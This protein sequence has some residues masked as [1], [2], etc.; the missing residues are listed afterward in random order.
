MLDRLAGDVSFDKMCASDCR[1]CD[2]VGLKICSEKNR[3]Q[4][5]S[6]IF[7]QAHPGRNI[8]VV[9]STQHP[10][11][12][13]FLQVLHLPSSL[14][15]LDPRKP[16]HIQQMFKY[17]GRMS[18]RRRASLYP[19]STSS[20]SIRPGMSGTVRQF[21]LWIFLRVPV[22]VWLDLPDAL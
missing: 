6:D 17:P 12:A 2:P 3:S 4:D 16:D 14:L 18:P 7:I 15:A 5:F 20:F 21:F 9:T 8:S 13:T 10:S 1:F 22:V 19:A 11:H